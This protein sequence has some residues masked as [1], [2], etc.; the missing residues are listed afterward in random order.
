MGLFDSHAHFEDPRFD[1]DREELLKKITSP[2]EI[3]PCGVERLCNVG[4]NLKTSEQSLA[5]A[6]KYG[7]ILAACGIHPEFA[8]EATP[9]GLEK[10]EK[11][12]SHPKAHALGEIGLD[13]KYETPARSVQKKAFRAQLALAQKLS[14]PV[15]IH[16][17]D[18]HGDVFDILSEFPAVTGVLHSYSGSAEMMRQL[19][20]KGW[21]ISFSG[22]VT[23]KNARSV[24]EVASL[25][26][27]DR[28]LI[29]TDSPYL[30]PVPHRGE[31]NES[32]YAFET[33]RKLAELRGASVD[34]IV[35]ITRKNAERFFHL[36]QK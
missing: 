19:V 11:L 14:L 10:L 9:A 3:C 1:E 22:T 30:A 32:D 2:S 7:F 18:A 17:R 29:E 34:E 16:D 28:L 5:L 35:E 13:Y 31:R 24:Q 15:I 23:F 25:V 27:A 26:P 8:E 33:A 12:L 21:F 20:K 4:S 6:E 36:L